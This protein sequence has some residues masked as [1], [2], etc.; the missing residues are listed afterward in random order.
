MHRFTEKFDNNQRSL[1]LPFN[2]LL[3]CDS[4]N[5]FK[6]RGRQKSFQLLKCSI[7]K[8]MEIGLL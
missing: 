7:E 3:G 2:T 8:Y 4:K 6:G 1:L 5:A